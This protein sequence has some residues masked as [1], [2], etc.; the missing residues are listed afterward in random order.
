MAILEDKE[1]EEHGICNRLS[2]S[3]HVLLSKEFITMYTAIW[4]GKNAY[5][6][7]KNIEIELEICKRSYFF[8]IQ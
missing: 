5:M 1:I 7:V 6:L 2:N 4:Q 3:G 8:D